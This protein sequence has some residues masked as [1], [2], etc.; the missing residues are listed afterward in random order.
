MQE[1]PFFSFLFFFFSRSS[2]VVQTVANFAND[3]SG[4]SSFQ[5]FHI[6]HIHIYKHR[7]VLMYNKP[8]ERRGKFTKIV[9]PLHSKVSLEQFWWKDC[10]FT[11]TSDNDE[12]WS[13]Q[14]NLKCFNLVTMNRATVFYFDRPKFEW[15]LRH[16]VGGRI[17]KKSKLKLSKNIWKTVPASRFIGG[18]LKIEVSSLQ[19]H[20]SVFC[21]I[22]SRH[23][24]WILNIATLDG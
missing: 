11:R 10:N 19:R 8:R 14:F 17:V 23:F 12:K 16:T 3:N 2:R 7:V 22:I 20:L 9:N 24:I 5:K 15:L 13:I 6:I 18:F 21:T 1:T 4:C